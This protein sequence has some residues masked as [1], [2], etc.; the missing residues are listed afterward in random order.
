[1]SRIRK[2]HQVDHLAARLSLVQEQQG[3]RH[4]VEE[5]LDVIVERAPNRPEPAILVVNAAALVARET[6]ANGRVGQ[7]TSESAHD[8]AHRDLFGRSRQAKTALHSPNRLRQPSSGQLVQDFLR[9][10]SRDTLVR[11]HFPDGYGAELRLVAGEL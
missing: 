10:G 2:R 3:E 4:I 11:G 7:K 9:V 1:M 8:V 6:L 5:F